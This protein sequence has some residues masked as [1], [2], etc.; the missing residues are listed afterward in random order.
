MKFKFPAIENVDH[1]NLQ[2]E[3]DMTLVLQMTE[4]AKEDGISHIFSQEIDFY[5]QMAEM[6]KIPIRKNIEKLKQTQKDL[7]FLIYLRTGRFPE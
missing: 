5:R 2:A 4:K 6:E 3:Y 1:S 7:A